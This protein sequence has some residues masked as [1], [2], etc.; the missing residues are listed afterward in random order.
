M[1]DILENKS[2]L[3]I[4]ISSVCQILSFYKGEAATSHDFLKGMG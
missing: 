3:K 2:D 4:F 1:Y